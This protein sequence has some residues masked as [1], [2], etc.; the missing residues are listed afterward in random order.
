VSL[1]EHVGNYDD[2]L[3]MY[4]QDMRHPLKHM[5]KI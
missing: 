1:D 3:E 4:E 5:S 2:V